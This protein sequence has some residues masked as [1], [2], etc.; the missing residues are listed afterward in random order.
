MSVCVFV[1]VVEGG[2]G[3]ASVCDWGKPAAVAA[4]VCGV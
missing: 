2:E 1:F 4:D 3:I